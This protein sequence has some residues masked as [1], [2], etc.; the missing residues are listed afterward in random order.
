MGWLADYFG[1]KVTIWLELI[2]QGTALL[3]FG[4]A[5]SVELSILA[6]CLYGTVTLACR[7]CAFAI[8]VRWVVKVLAWLQV[9]C[10]LWNCFLLSASPLAA[11][12]RHHGQLSDGV[13]DLVGLIAVACIGPL[14]I[15]SGGAK[16]RRA[17]IQAAE[18]N[19]S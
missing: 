5:Q 2:C 15:V 8:S 4:T 1:A 16:S 10:A 19:Q 6:A 11:Y 3:I 9:P 14:F 18:Q 17:R 13:F 7:R 12:M